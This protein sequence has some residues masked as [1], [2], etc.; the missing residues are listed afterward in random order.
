MTVVKGEPDDAAQRLCVEKND[1]SGDAESHR[2]LRVDQKSA[3]GGEAFVFA[4]CGPAGDL[5]CGDGQ[6][7]STVTAPHGPVEEASQPG[8]GVLGVLGEPGVDVDLAARREGGV[9]LAEPLQEGGRVLDLFAGEAADAGC[10]VAS[11]GSGP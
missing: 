7:T 6:G 9:P 10:D 1:D 3:Q 5:H 8:A 4:Q 11:L 2:Y